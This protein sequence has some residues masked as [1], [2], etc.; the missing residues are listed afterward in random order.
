MTALQSLPAP[1]HNRISGPVPKAAAMRLTSN[2]MK[3]CGLV[4][5]LGVVLSVGITTAKSQTPYEMPAVLPAAELMP[6]ELLQSP[7]YQIDEWIL[8]NGLLTKT[9]LRSALGDFEAEGPGMVAVRAAEIQALEVLSKAETLDIFQKALQAAL[10]RT[11]QSLRAVAAHPVDTIS[12]VPAGIGRFFRRVTRDVT[13]GVQKIGD[14]A[15]Q[16]QAQNAAGQPDSDITKAA[17][18]GAAT[19]ARGLV[20]YD[21]SRR[22]LARYLG[23]DPYTTNPILAQKMDEATW[24]VWGG[25]FGP[26]Q[27]VGLVPG[28]SAVKFTRDWVS[29]LV[30]VMTPGDLRVA[31]QQQLTA[32]GVE[33]EP[34]DRFLR[35]K[36][37]TDSIR[38]ALVESMVALGAG[39]G[40]PDI[41]DWAL[42]ADSETQARFMAGS[43]AILARSHLTAAPVTRL[44]VAGTLLGETA[45][46]TVVVPAAVDYVSWTERVADFVG[47]PDL[48]S[49]KARRLCLAGTLSPRTRQELA[50]RDWIVEERLSILPPAS[51]GPPPG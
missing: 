21:D 22:R 40:R 48:A 51:H 18:E 30:W 39:P 26:E 9:V 31:M 14:A 19:V 45:D 42:T 49:A 50:A 28:G 41:I 12:G 46:G 1:S 8:T 25:E 13:T 34:I 2:A 6:P 7:F 47:R 43:V 3:P 11:G 37:F 17:L 4:M 35:Q 23:V 20:G 15:R 36:W 38:L 5:A 24:V 33:Q 27:L 16:R 44:G 32:L 29:D 10:G